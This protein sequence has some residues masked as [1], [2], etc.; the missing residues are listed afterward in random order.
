MQRRHF[1]TTAEATLFAQRLIAEG[2]QFSF[3]EQRGSKIISFPD[4]ERMV[5]EKLPKLP[6][7]PKVAA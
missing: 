3:I 7:P 1:E 2:T 6:K 4:T 5:P